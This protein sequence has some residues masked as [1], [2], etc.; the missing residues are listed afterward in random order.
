MKQGSK[1]SIPLSK[2]AV[3]IIRGLII[4]ELITIVIIGGLWLWLRPRLVVDKD[5]VSSSKEA[6]ETVSVPATSTF[7]TVTDIP[8]GTFKYG[9]STSFAP[10]R[11][12]VDSQIQSFRPELRLR[13]IDPTNGSPGSVAG[14]RM[15]LNGELDFTQSSRPL[16]AEEYATAQRQGFTLEQRQVG[17]DG[18][19]VVVNH[20]LKVPGLTVD[21]LQQIYLGQ[22]TN[23]KHLG[24][25]DLPITPFSENPKNADT[26]FLSGKRVLEKQALGSNVQYVYSTTEAL[27][28]ISQTP[29]G[30]YYASAA[31]VV[32]QCMVKPLPLGMVPTQLIPPYREP[33]V[34]PNQCPQ[35]RNQINTKV[36][37][38]GSY[39]MT[40]KLFVIIKR[41]K[42]REQRAGEAYTKLLLTNQGQKGIEQAGFVPLR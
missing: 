38:N 19:A 34:P 36:I 42:N 40:T 9:G 5:P 14:I 13:Y 23:W 22:I 41:N 2:D 21:Q 33:L 17:I 4:G 3:Q 35:K 18:I 32:P 28:R 27:R 25:P 10:I 15:L 30:L 11:Q 12:L 16:T 20:A 24:G 37:K 39:P 26:V 31:G 29:G 7:K 1:R 8:I 6:T